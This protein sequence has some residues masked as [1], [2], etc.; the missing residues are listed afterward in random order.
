[1]NT[2]LW[3]TWKLLNYLVLS[4]LDLLETG[5]SCSYGR[6]SRSTH[7]PASSSDSLLA[8]SASP[9]SCSLSSDGVLA[10]ESAS[11]SSV[12]GNLEFLSGLSQRR[13]ISSTVLTSDSDL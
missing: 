2:D 12:S 8:S 7:L 3:L 1:M 10:A 13:T 5:D 6:S 11:V 4:N 9:Y